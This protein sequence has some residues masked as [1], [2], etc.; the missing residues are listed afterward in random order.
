[1]KFAEL[2]KKLKNAGVPKEMAH[3]YAVFYERGLMPELAFEN[4]EMPSEECFKTLSAVCDILLKKRPESMT[5]FLIKNIL[6]IP[7]SQ[8]ENVRNIIETFFSNHKEDIARLYKE[9]EGMY[10]LSAD[11]TEYLCKLI[12]DYIPNKDRAWQVFVKAVAVGLYHTEQCI[13]AV[14]DAV[15]EQRAPEV[16]YEATVNGW[17]LHPYYTDPVEAIKYLRTMF[18]EQTICKVILENP[19]YLYLY[20]EDGFIEFPEQKEKRS[21]EIQAIIEKYK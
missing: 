3:R 14:V 5:K 16:I 12:E 11:E 7:Y 1:M 13:E 20:K 8:V 9:K 4:D 15:G 19:E 2:E 17:L 18:D 10:Y 6:E 21:Q